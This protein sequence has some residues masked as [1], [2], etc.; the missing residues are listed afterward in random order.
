MYPSER[1]LTIKVATNKTVSK[2]SFYLFSIPNVYLIF[3]QLADSAV[4]PFE[5][6]NI[7]L[8]TVQNKK[9]MLQVG[10]P[11]ILSISVTPFFL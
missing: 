9:N 4:F 5:S 2:L 3:T 7:L 1:K 8:K 11:L 6:Q 10:L